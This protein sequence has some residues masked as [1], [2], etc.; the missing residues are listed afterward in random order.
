VL[1]SAYRSGCPDRGL[2]SFSSVLLIKRRDRLRTLYV[3]QFFPNH[4]DTACEGHVVSVVEAGKA[5]KLAD[6][7]RRACGERGRGWKSVETCG[8]PAKG[9]W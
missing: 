4:R 8:Q 7:L 3:T 9:M 1:C 2:F 5:W 6:S